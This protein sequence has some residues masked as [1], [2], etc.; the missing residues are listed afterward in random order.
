MSP[1]AKRY[2]PM[3]PI[4]NNLAQSYLS[5][6]GRK[7]THPV[8]FY[9]KRRH[10]I[11]PI[12]CL[13][14]RTMQKKFLA[15]NVSSFSTMIKGNYIYVDKTEHI[16]ALYQEGNRYHLLTRPRRFGKSLLI[17]TLEELF[18]GNREL[19]KGLWIE[20]SDFVFIKHPVIRLDFSG[21]SHSSPKALTSALSEHL[22]SIG[23]RYGIDLNEEDE[24]KKLVTHLIPQLGQI[25][26]VVLL[27]DG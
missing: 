11:P 2:L 22:M 19:F 10:L 7:S 26:K 21:M 13:P 20:T 14:L 16:Y 25:N 12:V 23:K 3:N 1:S 5:S 18:S 27:I 17:S 6:R 4:R 8:C 15:R 9:K 24:I